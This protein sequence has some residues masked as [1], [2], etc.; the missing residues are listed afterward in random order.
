M[1]YSA[2]YERLIARA[3]ARDLSGY[4]E[5]HHVI[6]RCIGGSDSHENIA[7]LTAE[8]HFIAHQLLVRINPGHAGLALAAVRM[9]GGCIRNK[10]YGWLR[11]KLAKA[12]RGHKFNVGRTASAETRA[13]MS[14]IRLGRKRSAEAV[15]KGVASHTGSQRSLAARMRMSDAQRGNKNSVGRIHPLETRAKI[16]AARLGKPLSPEHKAKITRPEIRAKM[17]EAAHARRGV[18]LS[19]ETK[20]KMAATAKARWIKFG[21]PPGMNNRR[22]V[23]ETFGGVAP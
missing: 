8:E 18:P 16:S 7:A 3:R 1:N 6:P 10:A 21:L 2:I 12:M 22:V 13:K 5:R 19:A 20:A 14:A 17:L 4:R 11:R 23:I 9:A 15:A